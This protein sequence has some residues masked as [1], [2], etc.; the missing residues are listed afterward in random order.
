MRNEKDNQARRGSNNNTMHAKEHQSLSEQVMLYLR[1]LVVLFIIVM[2]AFLMCFRVVVVSGSSM[3]D[4]LVNGDYLLLISSNL[5]PNS[6]Y[7]DIIVASKES[8][9]N[10]DPIVK[11]VIAT[12]GQVVDIDFATG[13]VYVDGVALDEDYTATRTTISEGV[14]FPLTVEENCL[15]VMG[16]NRNSSK[17]SRS[18]EIGLIDKREVL[19]KA[20]FLV[21]PGAGVNNENRDFSRIGALW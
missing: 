11:R 1:D 17:D 8:F 15:F 13:V 21:L 4:T 5:Y 6:K 3:N 10:G 2:V 16:D 14:A 20:I 19:G 12:E 18:P 9:E 7:G